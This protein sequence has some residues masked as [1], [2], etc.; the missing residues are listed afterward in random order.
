[1]RSK[2]IGL[3]LLFLIPG[4]VGGTERYATALL[5]ALVAQDAEDDFYVFLSAEARSLALPDRPNV[6]PVVCRSSAR[7]RP[8][9][10]L[11]E[12]LVLPLQLARRR[13]D[14]V[15]SL[16]YVG[17][18][19]SRC[20]R[21]V[22]ICDANYMT[23][24]DFTGAIKRQV[25]PFFVRQSARRA[26]QVLT[27]SHSAAAEI[28]ADTGIPKSRM[29]VTY[30]AGRGG[31][32]LPAEAGWPDLVQRPP[33]RKPYIVAFGGLNPHK[34][35]PGLLEA[36]SRIS[37]EVPHQLVLVGRV[38]NFAALEQRYLAGALG[39]RVTVTGYVPDTDLAPL[40]QNADL[41]VFPTLYE[42]F[43]LPVLEAQELGVPVACSRV[44]SLPEVAGDAAWFFD[45]RSTEDIA[46]AISR[47]LTDQ[48]LR[49][50]LLRKGMANVRRF[51]WADTASR[52]LAVYRE[53]LARPRD[54]PVSRG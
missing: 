48:V 49:E 36:F 40:L 35:M 13:I 2:R 6:H 51:S 42:G 46:A 31:Q 37:T 10:Y 27:L 32:P 53:V 33:I 4:W 29:T 14:L 1:M 23:L 12:Q 43:G 45:P 8:V 44:G 34:N 54:A 26:D 25:V 39:G 21:V 20:R 16:G 24:R 22:T 47:C 9:R 7:H 17:P 38:A 52:T 28:L 50:Q 5:E 15:H 3:N 18:L 41:F 19:V 30:L 11:W